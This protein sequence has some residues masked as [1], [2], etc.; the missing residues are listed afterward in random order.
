ML[1]KIVAKKNQTNPPY[2]LLNSGGV[3]YD[4]YKGA[5]SKDNMYQLSP[6]ED[7][8]FGINNVPYDIVKK[9]LPVLNKEGE[10]MKKRGVWP[11]NDNI[12]QDQEYFQKDHLTPGYTT[13]DDFGTD[14]KKKKKTD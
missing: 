8:F 3:R 14:G 9:I 11:Y 12:S 10:V 4:I 2:F 6:F 1:P 13:S 7:E 5:F